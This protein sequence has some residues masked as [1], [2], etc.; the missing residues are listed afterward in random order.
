[1]KQQQRQ[2]WFNYFCSFLPSQR[3]LG[4][5]VSAVLIYSVIDFTYANSV[6]RDDAEFEQRYRGLLGDAFDSCKEAAT[7]F[8]ACISRQVYMPGTNAYKK[9]Q[10]ML[11]DQAAAQNPLVPREILV[12][13]IVGM[14]AEG[15]ILN[16]QPSELSSYSCPVHLG[17][18]F[19]QTLFQR[20]NI[21]E[22]ARTM[23]NQFMDRSE[24]GFT[25]NGQYV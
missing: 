19:R 25:L 12:D 23:C 7:H 20:Y 14:L 5:L 4:F 24:N 8:A 13:K 17:D 11:V 3:T 6:D 2:S 21:V 10:D 18:D 1:M 16:P 22:S 9:M 15:Q